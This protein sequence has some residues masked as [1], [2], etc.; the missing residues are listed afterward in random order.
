MVRMSHLS[1]ELLLEAA[2]SLYADPDLRPV[3]DWLITEAQ[4]LRELGIVKEKARP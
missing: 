4:R 1:P 3:A 2:D